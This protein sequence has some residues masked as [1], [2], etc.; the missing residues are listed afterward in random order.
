MGEDEVK[1]RKDG[2]AAEGAVFE[3]KDYEYL[4]VGHHVSVYDAEDCISWGGHLVS[5]HSI[6]ENNLV[7]NHLRSNYGWIGVNDVAQE[8]VYKNMDGS[9]FDYHSYA[10]GQPN[11][12]RNED[13]TIIKDSGAWYDSGPPRRDHPFGPVHG[14]V[15]KRE[16]VEEETIPDEYSCFE[17]IKN[18]NGDIY[19]LLKF[20]LPHSVS[21]Q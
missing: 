16:K 4:A 5:I 13:Y 10:R 21:L 18:F 19:T 15:C 20:A 17:D 6:A 3:W 9:P 12:Y 2:W 11:N 1:D 14:Y 7:K 8:G